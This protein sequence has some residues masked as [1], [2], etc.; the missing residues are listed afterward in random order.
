MSYESSLIETLSKCTVIE[1]PG[2][3]HPFHIGGYGL[4]RF[5]TKADAEAALGLAWQMGG[6]RIDDLKQKVRDALK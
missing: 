3:R 2:E 6:H 4:H 5:S 1:T